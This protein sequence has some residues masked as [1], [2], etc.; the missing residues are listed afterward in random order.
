MVQDAIVHNRQWFS[1]P[2]AEHQQ[3]ATEGARLDAMQLIGAFLC[4]GDNIR[5]HA[6]H[7]DA[8]WHLQWLSA[9]VQHPE[10]RTIGDYER[11]HPAPFACGGRSRFRGELPGPAGCLCP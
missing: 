11:W 6:R 1:I 7:K 10:W 5:F 2:G 3:K 9:D 4:P 8:P